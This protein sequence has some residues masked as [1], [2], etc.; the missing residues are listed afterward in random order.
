MRRRHR[1]RSPDQIERYLRRLAWWAPPG[2]RGELVAE[3]RRHLYD[4]TRRAQDAGLSH[5][6]AQ[7]AAIEAF[8]PAW[9]IGLAERR[10]MASPSL[11]RIIRL[12]R[13]LR[14]IRLP[15]PRRSKPRPFNQWG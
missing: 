13:R 8:G 14:R 11:R 15:R 4:A 1:S 3:A 2:S 12:P 10:A 6:G 5:A 7:R 9:R